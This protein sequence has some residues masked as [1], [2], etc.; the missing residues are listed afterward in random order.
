MHVLL[1]FLVF[2]LCS[3]CSQ[4]CKICCC[5][6]ASYSEFSIMIP[7]IL[8]EFELPYY[9]KLESIPSQQLYFT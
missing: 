1:S 4:K 7:I 9:I 8:T 3:P 2:V 6:S 5:H